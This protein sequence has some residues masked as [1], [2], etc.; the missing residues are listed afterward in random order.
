M[1]EMPVTYMSWQPY[2]IVKHTL[3]S[4]LFGCPGIFQQQTNRIVAGE[5]L[6][7]ECT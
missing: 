1:I 6:N 7:D 4:V 5:G 3:D 2:L